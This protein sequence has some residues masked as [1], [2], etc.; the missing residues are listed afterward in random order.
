MC[1][2]P[3]CL[4]VLPK[5]LPSPYVGLMIAAVVYAIGGGIIEVMV[6]PVVESL[7][8]RREGLGDEP[9]AL[10]LLLGADGRGAGYDAAG[11]AAGADLWF[12]L[13]VLWACVPLYN[14]VRFLKVPL[15]PVPPRRN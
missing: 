15:M 11:L 6:S 3:A 7:P 9:A 8:G 2:R 5:V 1:S 10:I 13:P 14:L 4:G 12:L